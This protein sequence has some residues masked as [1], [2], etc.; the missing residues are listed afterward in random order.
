MSL[1]SC[2]LISPCP[3]ALK[4]AIFKNTLAEPVFLKKP[5]PV[6]ALEKP[7]AARCVFVIRNIF[8]KKFSPAF[9]GKINYG[10]PSAVYTIYLKR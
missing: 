7:F 10:I 9:C 3:A 8:L 1:M 2:R 4:K 6:K 5:V